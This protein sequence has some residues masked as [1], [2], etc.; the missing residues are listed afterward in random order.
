MKRVLLVS[1]SN[2]IYLGSA[3]GLGFWS[4]LDAVRQTSAVTF[5]DEKEARDYAA[6]WSNRVVDLRTV[7]VDVAAEGYATMDECAAAGLP[8]WTP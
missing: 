6:T 2:G 8:R 3:A 4:K 1:E 5:A 7:E